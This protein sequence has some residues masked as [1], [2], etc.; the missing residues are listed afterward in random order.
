MADP[1]RRATLYD[2][3]RYAGVSH[4]TVS[5]VINGSPHV[6]PKTL[7]R[8]QEAIRALG[9]Q[10]NKAAQAL[11][12]RRTFTLEVV[13]AGTMHYGPAQMVTSVQQAANAS[14]YKLV[15]TYVEHMT[16]EQTRSVMDNLGDVDGVIIVAPIQE[17]IY[18]SLTQMCPKPFVKVGAKPGAKLPSVII[19]QHQGC[20]MAVQHLIELGHRH[21]AEI[22]G[23]LHWYDALARHESWLDTLR[24]HHL[25]PGPVAPGDWTAA[26]GYAAARRLLQ[27]GPAFSALVVANDQMA[28]GAL[29]AL[30]EAGLRVPDDVSVVGFDDIPE[31]AY[32]EPPLTTVRQDFTALGKQSVEYLV[33]MLRHPDAP[34]HQ[35]MLYPSLVKRLSTRTPK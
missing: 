9:Y 14:G 13:A 10:P 29:R 5:R 19:D 22:C 24:V 17:D 8:V 7:R 30:H 25:E 16:L 26:S 23:P 12:T 33:E 11:V 18:E 3:A 4:Q 6:A 32:F 28:L 2:V 34:L 35:R 20:R 31:A 27:T 1:S 15:L 21:L